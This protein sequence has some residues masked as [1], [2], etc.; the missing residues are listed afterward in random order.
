M[1]QYMALA[2]T[3]L[4]NSTFQ[5]MALART[6][7]VNST[8]LNYFYPQ[9]IKLNSIPVDITARRKMINST[10]YFLQSCIIGVSHHFKLVQYTG[11]TC[12]VMSIV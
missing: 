12:I 5:Y 6:K 4:V 1:F 10:I 11:T 7:L 2:R 3:K 8:F 9:D